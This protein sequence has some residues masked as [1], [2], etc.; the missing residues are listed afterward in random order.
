MS[1]RGNKSRRSRAGRHCTR[2]R[3]SRA[4]YTLV[5]M[6]LVMSVL[7]ALA[8]VSWPLLEGA[9]ADYELRRTSETMTASLAGARARAIDSGSTYQFRFE[10]GGTRWFAVP[11]GTDDLSGG[12]EDLTSAAGL[13][14]VLSGEIPEGL[15]FQSLDQNASTERLD[16]DVLGL[17][18]E[19][20]LWSNVLWSAP[21]LFFA[22]GSADSSMFDIRDEKGE[23][24]RI[25]IRDL[26]GAA[27]IERQATQAAASPRRRDN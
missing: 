23:T 24:Y 27:G 11:A 26:T 7:L 12:M 19:G 17:V 10:P 20:S 5:E 1:M 16:Q 9:F 4:G 14:G 8:F 3:W 13:A 15:Q 6:L 21:V 18:P 2:A 22:D 25:S